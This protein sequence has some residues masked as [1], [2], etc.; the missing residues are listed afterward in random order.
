MPKP[1]PVYPPH[2][3]NAQKKCTQC[4]ET[5]AGTEF[6][7]RN[8]GTYLTPYCREC[9]RKYLEG[10]Y[11]ANGPRIRAQIAEHREANLEE[12]Q[13]RS[14]RGVIWR[15]YGIT[16]EDYDER[17]AAQDGRCAICGGTGGMSHMNAP[18]VIDHCHQ[19]NEVRGLLCARCNAGIGHFFDDP[20]R[21]ISAAAYLLRG[22][23]V[24]SEVS[25]R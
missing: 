13:E 17:L 7:L 3:A 1:L 21:L 10:Y 11:A 6:G 24:L 2:L 5:K 22:I 9:R 8:K 12:V 4:G 23:D 18:L 14:R 25:H 20:D 16:P 15:K 19:S